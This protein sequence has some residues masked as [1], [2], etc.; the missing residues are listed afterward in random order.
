M[1]VAANLYQQ[2]INTHASMK[3]IQTAGTVLKL[4]CSILPSLS[5]IPF[6]V[7]TTACEQF[8]HVL[9][10]KLGVKYLLQNHE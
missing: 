5:T 1:K 3:C 2:L 7:H 6:N 4:Y 9:Q 8:Y 10:S